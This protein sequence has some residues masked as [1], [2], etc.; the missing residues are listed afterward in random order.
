MVPGDPGRGTRPGDR[1]L[2][3]VRA[4]FPA[5][6]A[7]GSP[8]DT[9][10]TQAVP[11]APATVAWRA[12]APYA[13]R[14]REQGTAL[15]VEQAADLP[16]ACHGDAAR[17]ERVLGAL[18]A[19]AMAATAQGGVRLAVRREGERLVFEVGGVEPQTV[20]GT[21]GE[22]QRVGF[23][24]SDPELAAAARD[25][26]IMGGELTAAGSA[27]CLWLPV[28]PAAQEQAREPR[29]DWEV[30]TQRFDG[31]RA[32]IER[33]AGAVKSGHTGMP[34]ELRRAADACD[35]EALAQITHKL[36]G[37]AG[38]LMLDHLH[39][40]ASEAEQ[41]ARRREGGAEAL[42]LALVEP[43]RSVL[44]QVDA[45]LAGPQR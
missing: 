23:A 39:A 29:I 12:V 8:L 13:E 28:A 4:S 25:A 43:L 37:L 35:Y 1:R 11:F 41:A 21:G 20:H 2:T 42:A 40:L 15:M 24:T 31:R 18:L 3:D 19:R 10:V 26:A 7:S 17:L 38:N 30:L 16:A 33:L 36:K 14:A 9:S 34:E 45:Y 27:Y 6:R 44:A 5:H 32:F 22:P